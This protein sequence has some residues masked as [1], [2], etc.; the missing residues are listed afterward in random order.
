[1]FRQLPLDADE[2]RAQ[3]WDAVL[4]AELARVRG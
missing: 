1:V 3:K 4:V 2:V